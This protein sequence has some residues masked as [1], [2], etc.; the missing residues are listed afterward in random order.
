MASAFMAEVRRSRKKNKGDGVAL[1]TRVFAISIA[2]IEKALKPRQRTD[3]KTKLPPQYHQWLKAFNYFLAEKLPPH[4][5][6]VDLHIKIEKDHD[7][8]EKTVPWGPLYGMGREELLVLRK[9]LTELLNK[10]FIRASNSPAAAPV[11]MVKKPGGGIRFCVD[12]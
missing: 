8:N 9:T 12:Y 3:L 5:K 11:L 6:G 1:D 7:G 10:D 2:D 4:R